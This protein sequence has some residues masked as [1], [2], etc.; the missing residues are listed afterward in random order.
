MTVARAC[1]FGLIWQADIELDH[2][3]PCVNTLGAPDVIIT[4]AKSVRNRAPIAAINRGFVYENGI[5]FLWENEAT[6][7]MFDGRRVDYIPGPDW[8]G[9]LPAAFFSTVAALIIAWRGMIPF[10][11]SAVK[12]DD[13]AFLIGGHS[14]AGKSTFTAAL[15]SQGAK[16]IADDLSVLRLT[17]DGQ[18]FVVEPGRPAMRLFPDI[19]SWMTGANC[20]PAIDDPRGKILVTPAGEQVGKPTP[21]GGILF[22]RRKHDPALDVLGYNVLNDMVFRSKWVS[23]LPGHGTRQRLLLLIAQ[24]IGLTQFDTVQIWDADAFQEC[25]RNGNAAIRQER[26]LSGRLKNNLS[27]G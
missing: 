23:H 19:A 18:N 26:S 7:D 9:Y 14:G 24:S 3:A 21:L 12:I 20:E 27:F 22:L 17:D 8:R 4:R 11:A 6:F 13:E 5:R 25:G 1:A 15:V 16:L 2:F 10:H